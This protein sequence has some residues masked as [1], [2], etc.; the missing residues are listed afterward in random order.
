MSLIMQDGVIL[1][2]VLLRFMPLVS[3]QIALQ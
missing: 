2:I 3:I 1:D